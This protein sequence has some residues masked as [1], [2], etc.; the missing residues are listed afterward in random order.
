MHF[1]AYNKQVNKLRKEEYLY[2]VLKRAD[3][4]V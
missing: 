1:I 2:G 3:G 4:L